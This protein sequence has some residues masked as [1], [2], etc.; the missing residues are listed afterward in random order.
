MDQDIQT[1]LQPIR[2]AAA[3]PDLP[4]SQENLVIFIVTLVWIYTKLTSL[5]NQVTIK[6]ET[7]TLNALECLHKLREDTP[8]ISPVAA[9]HQAWQNF[10]KEKQVDVPDLAITH[11]LP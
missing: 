8:L 2:Q 6:R 3:T 10:L 5:S 11:M 7:L 1:F 4:A 9:D